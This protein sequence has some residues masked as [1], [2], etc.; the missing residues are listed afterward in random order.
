MSRTR[1]G[2]I[3]ALLLVGA[4]GAA[5]LS[6]IAA[7]AGAERAGK[8]RHGGSVTFGIEAESTGGFCLP[9]ATLAASGIQIASAIYDT[10]VVLNTKGQYVPYLA[11]SVT[12]NADYTR[13]TIALRPHVKFHDDTPLDAEALKLNLDTYRGQNPK[14]KPRLNVFMYQDVA[15]VDVTGPLSVVV[16]TRVPWVAFPAFLSFRAGILAPAQLADRASCATN[17]IGTGPFKSDV[18]RPN[19][20]LTVKR[21]PHYWRKGF[22]YLDAI[23]F[24][25]VTDIQARLNG[26]ASGELDLITT[27]SSLAIY[28]L[29]QD[30]A[31]GQINLVVSDKGA[32]TTYLMLNS[33][34]APFDDPIARRAASAAGDPREINQIRNKGL[35]TIATGPFPP[36]NPAYLAEST[37]L[38][39]LKLA[40]KLAKQYEDEHG[41]PISFEY[42]TTPDSETVAIAA[43]V[44]EQQAK[45]GIEMSIRTVDQST[46][47]S[48]VLAGSFTG[49]GFR[50]YPGGDP[51]TQYVWWHSGSPLNLGRI[52]DPEIDRLLDEGRSE[53][54]PDT[55]VK[56]YQDL[57]R[58][59]AQKLYNLWSWYTLWAAASQTDVMGVSGPSLPDGGGRPFS[60]FGGVIPVLGLYRT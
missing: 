1:R 53:P 9:D 31:N 52:N 4:L 13:W 19:E 47:I 12:P 39:S 2:R 11:K 30:A 59:F 48:E 51:D 33:S 7:P 18:W 57:N 6:A 27:S 3:T 36:D 44:K 17:M 10:L 40:K 21:N 22:P 23:E 24:R 50:N 41:Q 20:S 54:D 37:R 38:H 55:R 28:D 5:A 43:L 42:L 29:K 49:A 45:A 15:S 32:E 46:L 25:P 26:L 60:L 8:T 14:I 16:T 35:N 56:I 58:R 34:R